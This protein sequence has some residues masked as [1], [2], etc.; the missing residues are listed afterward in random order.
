MYRDAAMT[1]FDQALFSKLEEVQ[2]CVSV[3]PQMHLRMETMEQLLLSIYSALAKAHIQPPATW[4]P[5]DVGR[6]DSQKS[7]AQ[8]DQQLPLPRKS[9]EP[10]SVAPIPAARADEPRILTKDVGDEGGSASPEAKRFDSHPRGTQALQRNSSNCGEHLEVE[11]VTGLR[12]RRR[13]TSPAVED[14]RTCR[15]G[16][17]VRWTLDLLLG[18]R[19]G[20]PRLGLEKSA[21][22]H[23]ESPFNIGQF[24][25]FAVSGGSQIFANERGERRGLGG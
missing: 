9:T 20:D 14:R 8:Y 4:P 3:I 23:P 18:L 1:S 17:Y 7:D 25:S 21:V 2:R 12:R 22:V 5:C 11:G 15:W 6:T 16:G 13:S 19:A 10:N 24:L